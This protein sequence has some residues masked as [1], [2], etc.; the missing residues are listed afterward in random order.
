MY[1]RGR[2]LASTGDLLVPQIFFFLLPFAL[3]ILFIV[4]MEDDKC[5]LFIMLF[6]LM[7]NLDTF[8][9]DGCFIFGGAKSLE[10]LMVRIW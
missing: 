9:V 6:K 5:R 7:L 2:N 8:H 3:K 10:K 4:N 1:Q